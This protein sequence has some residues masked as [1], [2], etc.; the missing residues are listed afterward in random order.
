MAQQQLQHQQPG[1]AGPPPIP[2]AVQFYMVQ[3]NIQA[4]PFNLELLQGMVTQKTL[5]RE[6]LVWKQGMANWVKAGDAPELAP[7]FQQGPPP[8]PKA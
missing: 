2:G 4:G 8:V 6:T 3:N 5:T 1:Q 7:L